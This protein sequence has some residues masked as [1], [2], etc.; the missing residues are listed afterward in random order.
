MT[1]TITHEILKEK[2]LLL[3]Y[4]NPT[5]L[6]TSMYELT[7]YWS[8]LTLPFIQ[9]TQRHIPSMNVGSHGINHEH[10]TKSSRG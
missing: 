6:G 5:M 10:Q 1:S 4:E 7:I 2:H 3:T 9:S 8:E